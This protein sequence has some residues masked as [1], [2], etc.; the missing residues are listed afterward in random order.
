MQL[1]LHPPEGVGTSRFALSPDGR[2]LAFTP[3]LASRPM[4]WLHSLVTGETRPLPS[5]EGARAPFWK[6]DSQ[7]IGYFVGDQLKTV[8]LRG[9]SPVVVVTVD[10]STN[11]GSWGRSDVILMAKARDGLQKVSAT[12]G[13]VEAATVLA[14]NLAHG[15]AAFLPDGVHF[16]YVALPASASQPELRVGS[17]ES[18][19]KFESLGPTESNAIYAGGYLFFVRGGHIGGGSLTVQAFDPD[20]RRP[21]GDA[22]PLGLPAAVHSPEPL[23]AFS[24]SADSDRLVYLPR[25][26]A[27]YDLLWHNRSGEKVGTVGEPGVYR[28]LDISPDDQRVAVSR[29]TQEPGKP[30]RD[31]HLDDRRSSQVGPP[32]RV[33]DDPA[34]EADPAWSGDGRHLAFNSFD[35]TG[36]L[37]LFVRPSDGTGQEVR[38]AKPVAVIASPDWSSDN[39]HIVYTDDRDLW[40]VP[41]TGEDRTPSIFL[42]TRAAEK[43]PVFSP[44]GRWI[45]YTS[46]ATGRDEVHIRA[47][48]RDESAHHLV[49]RSGGWAPRWRSDGQELFFL[50]LDSTVMA[51]GIDPSS[52]TAVGVP[53][54]LFPT[55]L[56][57]GWQ[58]RPYDVTRDGQRFLVPTMRPGDDFRV[59]LNWR[60]LLPR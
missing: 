6:P 55:G 24:V 40:T 21:L 33:T 34:Y 14:G 19:E 13:P 18:K 15:A 1:T 5:T 52:G 56:R 44:D 7:E 32:G 59:V 36:N 27:L 3:L 43:E 58:Y 9:G 51:V 35:V 23:G 42:K 30:V 38:L 16:L 22:V 4:L 29:Q 46:D 47:F 41:M 54:G 11:L 17:L 57:R 60:A 50:S 31:G 45:A 2:Y 28:H 53:R 20:R 10:P 26:A 12:G 48:P 25:T 37:G 8:S 39:K 49:S